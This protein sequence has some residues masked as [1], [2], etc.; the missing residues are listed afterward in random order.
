[1]ISFVRGSLLIVLLSACGS[2]PVASVDVAPACAGVHFTGVL[3]P[4]GLPG[5]IGIMVESRHYLLSWADGYR[6][7][8]TNGAVVVLSPDG[9][10]VAREGEDVEVTGGFS[11]PGEIRACGPPR[12]RGG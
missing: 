10:L 12:R 11:R 6:S 3:E 5:G 1:V 8:E 2:G 7:A 4:L 9:T